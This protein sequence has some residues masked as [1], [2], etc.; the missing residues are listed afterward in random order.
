MALRDDSGTFFT[1]HQSKDE[2]DGSNGDSRDEA[3]N[4]GDDTRQTQDQIDET[5]HDGVTQ[6]QGIT[7]FSGVVE[8]GQFF[9]LNDNGY[10]F[11]PKQIITFRSSDQQ[12]LLQR[13]QYRSDCS[14]DF[15]LSSIVGACILAGFINDVQGEVTAFARFD[16]D[17]D[18]DVPLVVSGGAFVNLT[19]MLL[20]TNF[21]GLI[22]LTGQVA[23]V[24]IEPSG[25]VAVTLAG[26]V[27]WS[28]EQT[29]SFEYQVE[30][31][32]IADDFPCFG[33]GILEFTAGNPPP[34]G[35]EP[36]SLPTPSP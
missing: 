4:G 18:I 23:G 3:Q 24:T 34:P 10:R 1:Y 36:V 27:D 26:T 32:R 14:T 11:E 5:V 22:D 6:G 28:Q 15:G 16:L 25:T 35:T 2:D 30:G 13:V 12:A 20:A 7:Y 9:V 19:S 8:P 21:A 33:T 17:V 29:Y 31:V